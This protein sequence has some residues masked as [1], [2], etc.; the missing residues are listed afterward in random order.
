MRVIDIH[1]WLSA[2]QQ[3]RPRRVRA[4]CVLQVRVRSSYR[5]A[6]AAEKETV[7]NFRKQVE[8]SEDTISM[9]KP[10]A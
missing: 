2:E 8:S 10:F 7:Q 3:G 9:R 6:A 4:T 1:D 5:K